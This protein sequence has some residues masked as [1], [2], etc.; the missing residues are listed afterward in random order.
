MKQLQTEKKPQ[1]CPGCTYFADLQ[2][3]YKAFHEMGFDETNLVLIGGI[4][5]SGRITSYI[6]LYTIHTL[7]GRP[8]P[9]ALG[10]KLANPTLNVVVVSG[11]GDLLSIGGTHFIHTARKNIDLTVLMFD[12]FVYGLTKGQ[13]SPTSPH[14]LV[15]STTP[16]GN[17]DEPVNPVSL[18]LTSGATFVAQTFALDVNKTF[19]II[20]EAIRHRGFSFVNILSPCITYYRAEDVKNFRNKI[21][22]LEEQY[23]QDLPRAIYNSTSYPYY[24]GVFY[25][26]DKPTFEE[27]VLNG[28]IPIKS[29][30]LQKEKIKNLLVGYS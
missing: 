11:D 15:T 28:H 9:V 14:N 30:L 12:N 8:L 5:C 18:A 24:T 7:H 16:R 19:N 4:G 20:K 10:F 17:V 22:D 27:K 26:V 13:V 2:A 3:I 23:L 6:N 21:R 1:W 25:K 29:E